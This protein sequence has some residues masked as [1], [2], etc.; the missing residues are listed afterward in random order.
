[1]KA[2]QVTLEKFINDYALLELNE[3]FDDENHV[4]PVE[5]EISCRVMGRGFPKLTSIL[6][7]QVFGITH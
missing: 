4:S 1:M 7:V 2:L 3:D 5:R 6:M